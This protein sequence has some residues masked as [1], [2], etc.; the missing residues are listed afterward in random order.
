MKS[1]KASK[2][3]VAARDKIQNTIKSNNDKNIERKKVRNFR[4]VR[5]E[6]ANKVKSGK[7]RFGQLQIWDAL[8]LPNDTLIEGQRYKITNVIP[9]R[10]KSWPID[11]GKRECDE[12]FLG[13]R[14]NS[15][16]FKVN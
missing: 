11:R 1:I 3:A 13:T 6:D 4:I 7:K 14:R 16:I 10:Q 8:Q 12:I 2:L 9:I 15:R 5:I